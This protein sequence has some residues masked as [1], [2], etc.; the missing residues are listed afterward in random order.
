[1]GFLGC[2]QNI[3]KSLNYSEYFNCQSAKTS[4]IRKTW[5]LDT[6]GQKGS[7]MQL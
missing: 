2:N 6:Q 4:H 1:M 5:D 3:D 7:L